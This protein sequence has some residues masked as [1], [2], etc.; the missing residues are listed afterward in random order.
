ENGN[1]N[2]S[3]LSRRNAL[4]RFIIRLIELLFLV[5]CFS[6]L[7]LSTVVFVTPSSN[8]SPFTFASCKVF[9]SSVIFCLSVLVFSLKLTSI[10]ASTSHVSKKCLN[11]FSGILFLKTSHTFGRLLIKCHSSLRIRG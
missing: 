7:T 6:S 11:S 1:I 5:F 10:S 8:S 2:V 4:Q 9:C 3:F